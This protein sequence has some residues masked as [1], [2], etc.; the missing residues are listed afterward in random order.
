MEV[1]GASINGDYFNSDAYD[2]PDNSIVLGYYFESHNLTTDLDAGIPE[3]RSSVDG[4]VMVTC[5]MLLVHNHY[6]ARRFVL[7]L[8]IGHVAHFS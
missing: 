1:N 8:L 5:K 4:I 2:P 3:Y 7:L 6:V